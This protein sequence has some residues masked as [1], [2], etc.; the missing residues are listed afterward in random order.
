[1]MGQQGQQGMNPQMMDEGAEV[2]KL[3]EQGLVPSA[4]YLTTYAQ[5]RR[6]TK[7]WYDRVNT[8][9]LKPTNYYDG[10]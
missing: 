6:N 3:E 2:K 4:A 8:G 5:G 7:D 10:I 1:M 9:D